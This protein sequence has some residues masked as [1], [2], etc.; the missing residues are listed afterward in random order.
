MIRQLLKKANTYRRCSSPCSASLEP[1]PPSPSSTST[2]LSSSPQPSGNPPL[3][4]CSQLQSQFSFTLYFKCFS[5]NGPVLTKVASR[6]FKYLMVCRN[7]AVGTCSLVA[8]IGGISA[9]LLDNLKVEFNPL[10]VKTLQKKLDLHLMFSRY[11]GYQ[12]QFS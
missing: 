6:S 12:P 9:L 4:L 2:L 1:L 3:L 10:K 8:R 11:S 7:Q 5:D